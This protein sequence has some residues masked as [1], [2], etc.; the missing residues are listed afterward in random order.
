MNNKHLNIIFSVLIW[1]TLLSIV[2]GIVS[3]ILYRD[4]SKGVPLLR[5]FIAGYFTY[6]HR[7]KILPEEEE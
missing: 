1:F 2:V 4:P 5:I 7:F 3:L 6:R